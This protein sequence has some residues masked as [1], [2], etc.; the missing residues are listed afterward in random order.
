MNWLPFGRETLV[1][2]LSKEEVLDRL[3][4]VTRGT[5]TEG[6]PEIRSLFNGRVEEDG[7]RL[8]RVIEKGDNFLPLLQGKVE[9]TPRGSIIFARYQLFSTTRFF[10]WFWTG[11]LFGFSLFFFL[12][13]QQFL[14]GAV[15][16]SLMGVNYA[17][18]VFF[19]H[20]QLVPSRK[21]FKEVI[22]FPASK[23]ESSHEL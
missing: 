19:F 14:Q 13:A 20:R 16:L 1:S 11:V 5:R 18:A 9:D 10:L 15:C 6:L 17:L 22:N 7:F 23:A 3:A 2:A 4:A 12:G 21:L 8:S